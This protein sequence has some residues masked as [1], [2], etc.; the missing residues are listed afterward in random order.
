MDW[1]AYLLEQFASPDRLVG[2]LSYILLV[3]SMMMR[4]MKWLRVIAISAGVVSAI[5]GYFVLK[6]FVTVFWEIIFVSVNLIQLLIMEVENRRARFSKDEERFIQAVVPNVER[7]HA[8]R[9][10]KLAQHETFEAGTP[11]TVEGEP[12]ERLL[13]LIEGAVRIEKEGTIVGVCGHDD[14]IGEIGFMLGSSATGSAIVTNSVRALSFSHPQ[15]RALL[16][17]EPQLRHALES[18]FN[19]NLV[20]K[21]VKSN[22]GSKTQPGSRLQT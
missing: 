14:F 7:A 16:N 1:T 18:S 10:V 3:V 17:K 13:F 19:R 6:D 11:L 4:S 20:E 12:V 2:H 21:L 22:E 15:L 9:L 5:Y 8:K